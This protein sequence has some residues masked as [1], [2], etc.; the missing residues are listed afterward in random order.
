MATHT[1]T[2]IGATLRCPGTASRPTAVGQW[3][4]PSTPRCQGRSSSSTPTPHQEVRPPFALWLATLAAQVLFVAHTCWMWQ[5][6]GSLRTGVARR[7]ACA[8]RSVLHLCKLAPFQ[9][10]SGRCCVLQATPSP[11]ACTP[12]LR[13]SLV[14]PVTGAL[15]FTC[16]TPR[17]TGPTQRG[18][19]QGKTA[20]R[21]HC[22][23]ES[24]GPPTVASGVGYHSP[25]HPYHQCSSS[26]NQPAAML[27]LS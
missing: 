17:S 25:P 24:G 23:N 11:A 13:G 6:P 9:L 18:T 10:S 2:I 14:C 3:H 5:L 1:W 4:G 21:R 7:A 26:I 15:P 12:T 19:T 8:C 20:R 27:W 22:D 16:H